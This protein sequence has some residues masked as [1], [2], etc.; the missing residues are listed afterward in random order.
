MFGT[1]VLIWFL[2]PLVTGLWLGRHLNLALGRAPDYLPILIG[3]VLI[4]ALLGR[5]PLLGWLVYLVSFIFALGGLLL[6]RR[7]GGGGGSLRPVTESRPVTASPAPAR[8]SQV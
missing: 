5:V 8:P 2:S 7:S 1:L 4:L 6:A 3:G